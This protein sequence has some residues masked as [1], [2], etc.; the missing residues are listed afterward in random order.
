MIFYSFYLFT[1]PVNTLIQFFPW[2]SLEYQFYFSNKDALIDIL[3]FF[4]ISY[5]IFQECVKR[6]GENVKAVWNYI[7]KMFP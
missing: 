7:I 1:I 2:L 3:T 6:D 4:L 5:G